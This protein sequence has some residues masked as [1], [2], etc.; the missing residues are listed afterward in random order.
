MNET[1]KEKLNEI[2]FFWLAS[3]SKQFTTFTV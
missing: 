1:S 2:Q 3:V